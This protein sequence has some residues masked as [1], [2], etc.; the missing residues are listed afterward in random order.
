[1]NPLLQCPVLYCI[2]NVCCYVAAVMMHVTFNF[3][4]FLPFSPFV[5]LNKDL[6]K[7]WLVGLYLQMQNSLQ[8]P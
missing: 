5:M 6:Q 4:I 2:Y 1:M 3:Q 7:Y 8:V